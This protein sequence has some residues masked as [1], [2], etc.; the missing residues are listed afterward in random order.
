MK[1]R[2]A[3]TASASTP[4]AHRP[5]KEFRIKEA[6]I[7]TFRDQFIFYITRSY[8]TFYNEVPIN[9]E[10]LGNC[11]FDHCIPDWRPPWRSGSV[12][13][14]A[15]HF[16]QGTVTQCRN[17]QIFLPPRFYVKSILADFEASKTA[18]LTISDALDFE[19]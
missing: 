12:R 11:Y 7:C 3:L 14:S 17:S 6:N 19:F 16:R 1:T 18:I 10:L 9:I 15:T 2:V 4:C 8:Y 5:Q 13:T